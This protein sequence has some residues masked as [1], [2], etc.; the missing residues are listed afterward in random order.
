MHHSTENIARII[1]AGELSRE[2][3]SSELTTYVQSVQRRVA[4]TRV[5][6]NR[7]TLELG[8]DRDYIRPSQA[9]KLMDVYMDRREKGHYERVEA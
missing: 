6:L 2:V 7:L 4:R 8:F 5:R 9:F 3:N 1:V